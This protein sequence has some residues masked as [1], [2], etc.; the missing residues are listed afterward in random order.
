MQM[1]KLK[2]VF[3]TVAIVLVTAF[4]AI[5]I[6]NKSQDIIADRLPQGGSCHE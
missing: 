5:S 2:Y 6:E 4:Y 3:L 1:K